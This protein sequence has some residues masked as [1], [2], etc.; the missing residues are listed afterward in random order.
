[1]AATEFSAGDDVFVFYRMDKRCQPNRRYFAVLD[2]RHGTCRPRIGLAEGWVLASVAGDADP[3]RTAAGEVCVHYRWPHFFSESGHARDLVAGDASLDWYPLRDIKKAGLH[4]SLLCG[5]LVPAWSRPDLAIVA[6]CWGGSNK[7]ADLESKDG[8]GTCASTCFLADMLD[9]AVPTLGNGY[10]VWIVYIEDHSDMIKFADAAHLILG[11]NHPARRARATCAMYF[12]RPTAF[13]EKSLVAK[14]LGGDQTAA[15]VDQKSLFRLMKAVERAGLPTRFPHSSGFYEELTSKRWIYQLST[16][17]HLRVPPAVALPRMGA[18]TANQ[19]IAA[20]GNVRRL[21]ASLQ[22]ESPPQGDVSKG[23]VKFSFSRE[24]KKW[25]SVASFESVL[26]QLSKMDNMS[27]EMNG[28]PQDADVIILQEQVVRDLE[29]RVHVVDGNIEDIV[30]A[31]LCE[32]QDEKQ[33]HGDDYQFLSQDKAAE[34][35]MDAD[36]AALEDG[37]R[38]CRELTG[39]WLAWCRA[40]LCE[41]PVALRFD[42]SLKRTGA[43]GKSVVW[44]LGMCE[45]GFKMQGE[46]EL[47]AKI[48]SAVVNSCLSDM[49]TNGEASP[50]ATATDAQEP[51]NGRKIYRPKRGGADKAKDST[52]AASA[53]A[54]G[55]IPVTTSS[56]DVAES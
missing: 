43:G 49:K 32:N 1:M 44:T 21:Q 34:K 3:S 33:E 6:F 36:I 41:M 10:E 29:L 9:A 20:L 46:T 45:L 35:W 23:V 28:Q 12:L 26:K 27:E 5:G 4:P 38:Q 17:T 13:D 42:Y 47:S 31:N 16:V 54:P 30:F 50:T 53:D 55:P 40:Q 48:F 7:E 51:S 24:E 22:G 19:A 15:P 56:A 37:V 25:D 39:H 2:P 8:T 52:E 14:V 11:A 18:H